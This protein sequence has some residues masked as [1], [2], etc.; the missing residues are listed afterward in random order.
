MSEV[1]AELGVLTR[2]GRE[3]GCWLWLCPCPPCTD[4]VRRQ[5]PASQGG[6]PHHRTKQACPWISEALASS[7]VRS[8]CPRLWP[9]DGATAA[10][11]N[12]HRRSLQEAPRCSGWV[13]CFS[14]RYLAVFFHDSKT[15]Y[16]YKNKSNLNYVL[17]QSLFLLHFIFFIVKILQS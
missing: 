7:A 9:Q 11:A 13:P 5:S 6:S 8:K 10:P 3:A 4:I 17:F 16:G 14:G 12:R 1:H 2:T 15:L